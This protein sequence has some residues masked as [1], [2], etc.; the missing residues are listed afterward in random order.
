MITKTRTVYLIISYQV[1]TDQFL[2]TLLPAVIGWPSRGGCWK[3]VA[4]GGVGV[5]ARGGQ[6]CSVTAG[7]GEWGMVAAPTACPAEP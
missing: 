3:R 1:L 2:H 4:G 6:L 7:K 5:F